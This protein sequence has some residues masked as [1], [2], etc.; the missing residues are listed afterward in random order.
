MWQPSVDASIPIQ[1]RKQFTNVYKK[2][3]VLVERTID[4]V[5]KVAIE[6]AIQTP[7]QKTQNYDVPVACKRVNRT[8]PVRM[9]YV[10]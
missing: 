9:G 6:L 2:R 10:P 3:E 5:K 8:Q 4:V 1:E 7:K